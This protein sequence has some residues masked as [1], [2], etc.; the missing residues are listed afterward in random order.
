MQTHTKNG[1]IT[2]PV[3]GGFIKVKSSYWKRVKKDVIQ[4]KYVYLMVLPVV[5]YFALFHYAP[6]YGAQ[7]AFKNYVPAKGIFGSEW[8]GL[9]NFQQFFNSI[10]FWRVLKNTVLISL[11]E[12]VLGFPAPIV[13]A[14]MLNE[15]RLAFFK[16]AVQTVVYIPHFI[17]VVIVAGMAIDFFSLDGLVNQL[18]QPLGI[19]PLKFFMGPDWFRTIF[20]GSGIWQGVG[21]GSIIYLA[22]I[23]SID[24]TLY[25]AAKVDGA[26]RIKQIFHI[27]IPGIAPTIIILF[28]LNLGHFMSVGADKIIL[29]YNP[30]MYDTADTISTFVYRKGLL[31]ANYSFSAAVG[32]FNSVINFMLLLFANKLSRS[33]TETKLW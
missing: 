31:E 4:N 2:S 5:L 16:R 15:V 25:E 12:L 18:L 33:L 10:Y 3:Q 21:W 27:T 32:L 8:A 28:I 1:A 26:G 29:L 6:M 11:Y 13:L 22:A 14:L 17:S 23:T 9:D 24:P 30:M 20:V 19:G 7:I